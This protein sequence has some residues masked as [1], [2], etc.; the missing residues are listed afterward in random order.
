MFYF[1][2]L[3]LLFLVSLY[4]SCIYP[5]APLHGD[6]SAPDSFH[7]LLVIRPFLVQLCTIIPVI[8]V[9]FIPD[10]SVLL[11]KLR[12]PCC[13]STDLRSLPSACGFFCLLRLNLPQKLSLEFFWHICADCFWQAG[14][15]KATVCSYH[16]PAHIYTII[17]RPTQLHF[18]LKLDIIVSTITRTIWG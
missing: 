16:T 7:L 11:S 5:F 1:D 8:T 13:L 3:I 17:C 12:V 6:C 4:T 10:F 2:V 15:P 9:F 14:V 18:Y